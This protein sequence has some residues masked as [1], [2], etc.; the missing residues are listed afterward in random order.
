MKCSEK[1]ISK[2]SCHL[3]AWLSPDAVEPKWVV[4][5]QKGEKNQEDGREGHTLGSLQP[6]TGNCLGI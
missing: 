6:L 2:F 3:P 5:R 1:V 4:E